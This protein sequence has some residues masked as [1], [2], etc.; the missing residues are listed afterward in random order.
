MSLKSGAGVGGDEG[1]E[2]SDT[3]APSSVV[4]PLCAVMTRP[5]QVASSVIFLNLNLV[6]TV[7]A[8]LPD[9]CVGS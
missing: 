8:M 7:E 3:R 2:V 1:G 9:T 5:A 6:N 4:T